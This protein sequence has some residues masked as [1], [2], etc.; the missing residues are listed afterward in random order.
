MPSSINSKF[1]PI[2]EE[3]TNWSVNRDFGFCYVPDFVALG[4]VISDF[5]NPDFLLIGE[6]NSNYGHIVECLYRSII[7]N[8]SISARLSLAE[9]EVCKVALNAY[10]TTKISFANFLGLLCERLDP[11]I[12]VDNVTSTIGLDK[13]IGTR[14]F[15]SGASYGGTCFPRDTWAFMKVSD[16]CGLSAFQMK[17]NELINDLVDQNIL[18][19][20]HKIGSRRIGLLGLGFKPGTPVVTEGLALKLSNLL[21]GDDYELFA[22][23]ILSDSYENLK[24]ESKNSNIYSSESI[25]DLCMKVDLLVICNNDMN[26]R[27]AKQFIDKIIDPWRIVN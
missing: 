13:R 23:D 21:I 19:K 15:K 10:I 1:I 27:N 20:I 16:N 14:Y 26:Y 25:E 6:S 12:N 9:A 8:N 24:K 2:I 22:F 11:S 5:E 4:Q 18:S 17:S 3:I 7:K